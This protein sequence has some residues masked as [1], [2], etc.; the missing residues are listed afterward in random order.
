MISPGANTWETCGGCGAGL[1][2][3]LSMKAAVVLPA[4]RASK[5][6]AVADP[7][8]S[9]AAPQEGQHGALSGTF[10]E[11][12]GQVIIRFHPGR[13]RRQNRTCLPQLRPARLQGRQ[14]VKRRV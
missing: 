6:E 3:G 5:R 13:H 11:Q 14:S 2:V 8:E 12:A 1:R 10:A 4:T 7:A 9:T